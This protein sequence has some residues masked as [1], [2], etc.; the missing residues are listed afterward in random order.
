MTLA[1]NAVNENVKNWKNV[2]CEVKGH[3]SSAVA[4]AVVVVVVGHRL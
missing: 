4:V 2:R 1:D 3:G